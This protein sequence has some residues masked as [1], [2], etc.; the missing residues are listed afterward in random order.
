MGVSLCRPSYLRQPSAIQ[1]RVNTKIMASAMRI[2][3][4]RQSRQLTV[5]RRS[6]TQLTQQAPSKLAACLRPSLLRTQHFHSISSSPSA[7]VKEP[8]RSIVLQTASFHTSARRTILPAGPR[9]YYCLQ[10]RST[11]TEYRI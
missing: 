5:V 9:K 7:P 10:L 3:L 11:D 6:C 4:L 2:A 1:S 8:P